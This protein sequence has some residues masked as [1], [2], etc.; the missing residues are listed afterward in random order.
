[1]SDTFRREGDLVVLVGEF[2]KING[3]VGVVGFVEINKVG[4]TGLRRK[5]GVARVVTDVTSKRRV[6]DEIFQKWVT[7]VSLKRRGFIRIKKDTR[8]RRK[9]N[10]VCLKHLS[11]T[12][13]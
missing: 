7:E 9:R 8:K 2:D 10:L 5:K 6:D 4:N 3:R 13:G 1:M 12:L 11:E